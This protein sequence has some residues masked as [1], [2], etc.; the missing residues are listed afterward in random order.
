MYTWYTGNHNFKETTLWKYYCLLFSPTEQNET[1]EL[2]TPSP[3]S[4]SP[5]RVYWDRQSWFQI[6]ALLH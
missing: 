1:L 6:R 5:H 2:C 4:V 3:S